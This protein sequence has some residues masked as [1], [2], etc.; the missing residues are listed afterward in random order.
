MKIKSAFL[1]MRVNS[2][3][4]SVSISGRIPYE[5]P[6]YDSIEELISDFGSE[7]I[8]EIFNRYLKTE[9]KIIKYNQ[10]LKELK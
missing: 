8:L 4:T 2:K 9:S 10:T 7:K 1:E 5:F 6:V 3:D